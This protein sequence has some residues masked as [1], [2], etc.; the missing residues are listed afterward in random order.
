MNIKQRLNKLELSVVVKK[1]P[2]K[3]RPKLSREQWLNVFGGQNI[4]AEPLTVDQ[5]E[6][7]NKYRDVAL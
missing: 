2:L 6:W 3:L 5:Q 4:E 1:E 7:V